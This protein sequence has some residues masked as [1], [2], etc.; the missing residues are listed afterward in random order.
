M[1]ESLS[2]PFPRALSHPAALE[3]R[4]YALTAMQVRSGAVNAVQAAM[5]DGS[6][7]C[8]CSGP[9]HNVCALGGVTHDK[10]SEPYHVLSHAAA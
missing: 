4:K 10:A 7:G 9:M 5:I 3:Q 1:L 2:Q 8:C 6:F